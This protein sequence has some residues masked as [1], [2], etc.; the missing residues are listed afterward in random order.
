MLDPSAGE[1]DANAGTVLLYALEIPTEVV[2]CRIDGL[3]QQS[4]QPIPGR[5]NLR[6]VLFCDHASGTVERDALL[7]LDAKVTGAG[8]ALLQRFQQLWMCRDAGA[9]ADQ[10]N[11]RAFINVGRPSRSAAGT[12]R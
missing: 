3:A 12:P 6:Q 9:A 1:M 2:M 5:E 8:A 7:D 11:R 4:L 10:F